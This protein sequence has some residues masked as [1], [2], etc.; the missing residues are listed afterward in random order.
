MLKVPSQATVLGWGEAMS[1]VSSPILASGAYFMYAG[2]L[3]CHTFDYGIL[4][5]A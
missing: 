2:W 5:D 3:S 1:H 4:L